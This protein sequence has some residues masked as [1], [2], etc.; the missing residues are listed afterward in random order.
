MAQI[1]LTIPDAN[2]QAMLDGFCLAR[3]FA[4]GFGLTK[5][6]FVKADLINYFKQHAKQGYIAGQTASAVAAADAAAEA[7]PVT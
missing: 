6:Q 1:I 5:A 7:I 2:A 3:N 4:P